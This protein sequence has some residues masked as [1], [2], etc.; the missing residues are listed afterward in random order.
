MSGAMNVEKCY[1]KCFRNVISLGAVTDWALEDRHV[2][3]FDTMN[4]HKQRVFNYHV[5]VLM[6]HND[7]S[8][9]KK[10]ID[11]STIMFQTMFLHLPPDYSVIE[12]NWM[13]RG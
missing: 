7:D 5:L 2:S 4:H 3:I 1:C 10:Q 8:T 13:E 6:I 9:T 12:D 11:I